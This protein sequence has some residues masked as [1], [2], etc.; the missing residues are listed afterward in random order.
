[1]NRPDD[2]FLLDLAKA[3]KLQKLNV[4]VTID[5]TNF[6]NLLSLSIIFDANTTAMLEKC[7]LP[8]LK[9]LSLE[10]DWRDS[11]HLYKMPNLNHFTALSFLSLER[12]YSFSK[13]KISGLSQ[14]Q[15]LCLSRCFAFKS[16]TIRFF[17]NLTSLSWILLT[18][19]EYN[20]FSAKDMNA[21]GSLT[22]LTELE[23]GGK[24]HG[25]D[26]KPVRALLGNLTSFRL[27]LMSV[28]CRED[29]PDH[30]KKAEASLEII[31]SLSPKKLR[32]LSLRSLPL[33]DLHFE[34]LAAFSKLEQLTLY[35]L[36][37]SIPKDEWF[38]CLSHLPQ[39]KSL[40]VIRDHIFR[41]ETIPFLP[42][43][44]TLQGIAVALNNMTELKNLSLQGLLAS[45]LENDKER[46]RALMSKKIKMKHVFAEY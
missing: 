25:T 46:L 6:S 11:L 28:A 32:N 36:S 39:L 17:S 9:S 23:L 20:I 33:H 43:K 5:I 45:P 7:Q 27:N 41:N 29:D 44:A 31:R 22:T 3:T 40:S 21:I 4:N 38:S 2:S 12:I 13:K 19:K 18:D 10:E 30:E 8:K 26:F 24:I 16:D 14:L 1:M 42:P 15:S 37:D 34:A 35:V